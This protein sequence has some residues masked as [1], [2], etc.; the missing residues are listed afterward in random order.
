[1]SG[2]K[3]SVN[4]NACIKTNLGLTSSPPGGGVVLCKLPF[5]P[6]RA[7]VD[8]LCRDGAGLISRERVQRGRLTRQR[9]TS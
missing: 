9:T 5:L 3:L 7:S 6:I 2:Q 1:M 4:Y 8:A